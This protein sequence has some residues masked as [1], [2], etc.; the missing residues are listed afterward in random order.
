[1]DKMIKN[2]L[3]SVLALTIFISLSPITFFAQELKPDLIISN[4]TTRTRIEQMR[5]S[6]R[7]PREVTVFEYIITIKNIGSAGT[8]Q[9]FYISS[10][11][12]DEDNDHY[13]QTAAVN[14]DS[15]FIPID[16]SIDIILSKDFSSFSHSAKFIINGDQIY[17]VEG[18]GSFPRT[19]EINIYNNTFKYVE[20]KK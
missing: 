16:G 12:L 7:S 1:M 3:L 4:V 8:S 9:P 19:D 15:T 11:P 2:K 13:S 6:S 10:A 17:K 14:L 18:R 5:P 20:T